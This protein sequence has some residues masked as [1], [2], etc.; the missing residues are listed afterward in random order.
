M[1]DREKLAEIKQG[2]DEWAET[3][4]QRTLNRSPEPLLDPHSHRIIRL[5]TA[6]AGRA[7][8]GETDG[9]DFAHNIEIH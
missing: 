1:F 7:V 6:E 9:F 5:I 8:A 3:A 4:L 2:L